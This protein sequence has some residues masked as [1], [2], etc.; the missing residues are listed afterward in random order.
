MRLSNKEWK[1]RENRLQDLL[2]FLKPVPEEFIAHQ[3]TENEIVPRYCDSWEE[4]SEAWGEAVKVTTGFLDSLAFMLACV[5]STPSIGD[6]LWIKIISPPSSGKSTLA[7]ALAVAKDYV[8]AVSKISGFH[9]GHAQIA[10]DETLLHRVCGKTLI[11]KDADTLLQ[12]SNL[13][14]IFSELRDIY[15]RVTRSE[16]RNGIQ[17]NHEDHYMTVILCGTSSIHTMDDSELGQ[18]FLD[19]VL[20]EDIDPDL[21]EDILNRVV[22]KAERAVSKEVGDGSKGQHLPEMLNAMELTGGYVEFLRKRS[23]ELLNEIEFPNSAKEKIKSFARFVSYMRASPSKLQDKKQE[24]ELSARLASQ[25][26]RAAMCIA[27]VLNRD[28]I[29]SEVLRIVRLVAVHTASGK[30]VNLCSVLYDAN[31]PLGTK[32]ISIRSNMGEADVRRYMRFLG[33]LGVTQQNAKRQW[34]LT[35]DSRKLHRTVLHPRK[36][37]KKRKKKR[38]RQKP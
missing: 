10:E 6:Q 12:S 9:T 24:R 33:V 8:M 15:D 20:M 25:L 19:F 21:E 31:M 36:I 5:C 30:S 22:D 37:G 11:I 18:R 2:D 29:D 35:A 34:E 1:L 3:F 23:I 16:Y 26:V 13:A 32:A 17:R 7:E 4:L 27:V 28:A 38:S 14:E